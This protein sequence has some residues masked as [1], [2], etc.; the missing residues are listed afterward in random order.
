M[1]GAFKKTER[2]GLPGGPNEMFTYTTGVFSTQGYKADS[3]DVDNPFNIIPSG[4]IT[5]DGV[6]FPVHGVDNLGNSSIM[7]PGNDYKFPGDMVLERP[8]S[9]L[10]LKSNP[11]RKNVLGY[12]FVFP[13]QREGNF[14][15]GAGVNFLPIGT[16]FGV[17]GIL[18]MQSDPVFKGVGTAGVSQQI[19]DFNIGVSANKDFLND[20]ET[21]QRLDTPIKP[22]F[23][24]RYTKTFQDGGESKALIPDTSFLN[25]NFKE[26]GDDEILKYY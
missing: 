13:E 14:I 8:I 19:G 3:P 4:N 9:D 16:Q 12:G 26:W 7:L 11:S 17:T 18:P 20:Y 2:R 25:T 10:T 22:S 6:E 5:M 15:A 23:N 21:G 24:V 1:K